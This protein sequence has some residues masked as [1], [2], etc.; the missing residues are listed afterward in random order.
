MI[1]VDDCSTD[2]SV[3]IVESYIPKFEGRLTLEHMDKNSGS[4]APPRNKGLT[5][6][7]GEYVFFMDADDLI[8]NTA[9]EDLH[10]LAK[11]YDAD[12]VY[13][14]RYYEFDETETVLHERSWQS[15][16]LVDKPTLDPQSLAQRVE[17]ISAG[18]YM[19]MVCLK[20]VSRS[21]LTRHELIFPQIR[22]GEDDVWTYGL[23]FYAKRFLR[24]PNAA[25]VYRFNENSIMRTKKTSKQVVNFRLYPVFHGF[26]HLCGFMSPIKFFR[27]SS[28]Y[29]YM[30]L[31]KFLSS[32]FEAI[33]MDSLRL[34]PFE[35]YETIWREFGKN[36]GEWGDLIPVLCTA[37]N[38]QRKINELNR[39]QFNEFV[40]QVQR[41]IADLE[42]ELSRRN[43]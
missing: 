15:G 40:A 33:V 38:T 36:F 19:S 4:P 14:E 43:R 18:R 13:C 21:L 2:N 12:V 29:R 11:N 20:F 39:Q 37:L 24:V 31:E 25:Y 5:I 1:V 16:E 8:I 10:T 42:S 35:V 34:Q 22:P 26:K 27:Q 32:N 3:A 41:R 7:Q 23:V 17:N 30:V 6:A 28:K 9:L